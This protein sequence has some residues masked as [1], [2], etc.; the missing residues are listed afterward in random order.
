MAA[1]K[2]TAAKAN[3]KRKT[4]AR[5]AGKTKAVP[6]RGPSLAVK[7]LSDLPAL[8][9]KR[10]RVYERAFSQEQCREWGEQTK[11]AAVAEE[12]GKLLPTID[13]ALKKDPLVG[14]SRHRFAYLCTLL[15]ELEDAVAAQRT[16]DEDDAVR[17][18]RLEHSAA[19]H[20]AD[21]LRKELVAGLL[22]VAAGHDAMRAK[23]SERNDNSRTP[24]VL[25]ATMAGLLQLAQGLRRDPELELLCDDVGLD[26]TKLGAAA[27]AMD[28]LAQV[29]QRTYGV[30]GE[31]DAH[32]TNIVEGRV[33]REL[34]VA[35][36][37]FLR[38]REYGAP[39]SALTPGPSLQ[40][41]LGL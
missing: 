38:A 16:G 35:R 4:T 36:S 11:A 12:A 28:S 25:V 3:A 6:Q 10:R 41:V 22:T 33:L 8:D 1:K 13:S 29:N 15:S 19:V 30:V 27:A 7:L 23:I 26:A 18:S 9:D 31:D 17:A 24:H 39:V 32:E 20:V 2:K 5:P 37:A 40:R 34:S 14:Y 21:R